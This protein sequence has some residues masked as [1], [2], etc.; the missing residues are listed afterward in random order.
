MYIPPVNEKTM[1][2]LLS[3]HRFKALVFSI[4]YVPDKFSC[5]QLA[6]CKKSKI[7]FK[8]LKTCWVLRPNWLKHFLKIQYPGTHITHKYLCS[9]W[10]S[11]NWEINNYISISIDIYISI[12][13]DIDLD[14]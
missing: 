12:D 1:F 11:Y 3:Q 8:S 13:R 7:S 10:V 6:F 14:I 4:M 2:S 5:I 9:L